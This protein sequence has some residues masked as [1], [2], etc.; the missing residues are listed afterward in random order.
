MLAKL[1]PFSPLS[2]PAPPVEVEVDVSPGTLP[3]TLLV[4][5][6]KR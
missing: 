3:K 5:Q 4:G 2:I 6:P 1:R